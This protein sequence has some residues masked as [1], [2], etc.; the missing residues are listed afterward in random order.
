MS[1]LTRRLEHYRVNYSIPY[2]PTISTGFDSS[3]RTLV[4]DGWPTSM[5]EMHTFG[6]RYH[7]ST[8]VYVYI[9]HGAWSMYTAAFVPLDARSIDR[10]SVQ[11][12]AGR[13]HRGSGYRLLISICV[14]GVSASRW[15]QVTR[16]RRFL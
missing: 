14:L 12:P 5:A 13:H 6:R 10:V 3:P 2:I 16:G 1:E 15:L 11:P 9:Q 7:Y 8:I 4:S